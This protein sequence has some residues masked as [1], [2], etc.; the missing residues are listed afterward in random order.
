MDD[1]VCQVE[2]FLLVDGPVHPLEVAGRG[3]HHG[4]FQEGGLHQ[5][6]LGLAVAAEVDEPVAAGAALHRKQ[7]VK[8]ERVESVV[9]EPP[10]HL[11]SR[12]LRLQ[13]LR[14]FGGFQHRAAHISG[15]VQH[16]AAARPLFVVDLDHRGLAVGGHAVVGGKAGGGKARVLELSLQLGV[17]LAELLVV[18]QPRVE[19]VPAL[20]DVL[21]ARLPEH[22]QQIHP[23]DGDIPQPSGLF[24]VPEHLVDPRPG[25]ELLPHGGRVGLLKAVLLQDHRQ[26]FGQDPRLLPVVR[27]PGQDRGLGVGVHGVGVLGHDHVVQPARGRLEA[28]LAL[29]VFSFLRAVAQLP[30]VLA[31]HGAPLDAGLAR[32]VSLEDAGKLP[33]PLFIH[34]QNHRL[35]HVALLYILRFLPLPLGEVARRS[36]DGEGRCRLTALSASLSSADRSAPRSP[37]SPPGA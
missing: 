13:G 7:A 24:R 36:R 33:Q 28:L 5:V 4:V 34:R 26:D 10:A 37:P 25:L 8:H 9:I 30:P 2:E 21:H 18:L 3:A 35:I 6:D 31:G 1:G 12:L 16:L 19:K 23:L 29:G 20:L 32:L 14:V 17:A 22:V 11:F 15:V 27:L